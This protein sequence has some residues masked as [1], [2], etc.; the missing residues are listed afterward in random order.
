MA[1]LHRDYPGRF[2]DGQLRT[3]QRRIRE[4]RHVMAKALVHTGLTEEEAGE[5]P[6]VVG[7]QGKS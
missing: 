1:R 6:I 3:L 4:W 5:E 2:P 7:A